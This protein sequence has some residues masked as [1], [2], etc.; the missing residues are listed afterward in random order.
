VYSIIAVISLVLV[1]AVVVV[2]VASVTMGS[3][4]STIAVLG[5][6][7]DVDCSIV[8]R[9]VNAIVTCGSNSSTVVISSFV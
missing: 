5:T 2:L 9:C 4:N 1:S 6:G 7:I 8:S 3:S